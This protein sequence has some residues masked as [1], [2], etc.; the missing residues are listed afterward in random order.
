MGQRPKKF[1]E[2]ATEEPPLAGDKLK[3]DD[4]LNKE[5]MVTWYKVRESKYSKK[6]SQTCLAL[7]YEIDGKRYIT[8]TGSTV[9]LDQIVRY[10]DQIPFLATVVKVDRYYTFS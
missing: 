1:S 10:R 5:I 2:F 6:N 9:L 7:Q 3:L 4:I 8:F